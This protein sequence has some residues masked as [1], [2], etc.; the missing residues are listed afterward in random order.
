MFFK[1][2]IF[3]LKTSKVNTVINDTRDSQ[4][5][6]TAVHHRLIFSGEQNR[7]TNIIRIMIK[8]KYLSL[9]VLAELEGISILPSPVI[10]TV[11]WEEVP[12]GGELLAFS[13]PSLE[14]TDVFLLATLFF[15]VG[16]RNIKTILSLSLTTLTAATWRMTPVWI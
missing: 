8:Q 11:G 3:Q 12:A 6:E 10:V 2:W 15:S 14:N 4:I 7:N 9:T 13:L 16:N 1:W 5:R